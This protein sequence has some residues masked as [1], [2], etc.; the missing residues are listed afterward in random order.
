MENVWSAF[1]C[2]SNRRMPSY[3]G[4][5]PITYEQI[6]AWQKLTGNRLKPREITVVERLDDLYRKI[7]N[8]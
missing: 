7:M 5:G 3:S 8:E 2:L 4:V 6:L 1:K